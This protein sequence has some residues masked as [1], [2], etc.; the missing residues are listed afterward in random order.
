[1]HLECAVSLG[2]SDMRMVPY[3]RLFC[4]SCKSI[5]FR[6]NYIFTGVEQSLL[7]RYTCSKSVTARINIQL[8]GSS[9]SKSHAK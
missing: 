4:F 6:V 8:G 9:N 7:L 3:S 5:G 1:M 2:F